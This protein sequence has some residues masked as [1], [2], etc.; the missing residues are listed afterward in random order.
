MLI[1]SSARTRVRTGSSSAGGGNDDY[2]TPVIATVAILIGVVCVAGLFVYVKK[3]RSDPP[4]RVELGKGKNWA[5]NGAY[6][7]NLSA[8]QESQPASF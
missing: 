7:S 8:A 5:M 3:K 6:P 4:S 2:A 1:L